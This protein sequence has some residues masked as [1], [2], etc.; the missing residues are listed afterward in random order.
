MIKIS[1]LSAE[2]YYT[3]DGLA[4]SFVFSSKKQLSF[5]MMI[6]VNRNYICIFLNDLKTVLNF[7]LT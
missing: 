7:F 3:F 4:T 6:I 5:K 1:V 2:S